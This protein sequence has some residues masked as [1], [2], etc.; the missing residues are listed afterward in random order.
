MKKIVVIDGQ[1]GK[2][3]R[4]VIERLISHSE[5]TSSTEIPFKITAVGTNSIAAATMLKAG[6]HDCA[7]GENSVIVNC[8][9]ANVVIGPIGIVVA[10]ALHGEVTAVMAAAV[11]ACKAQK[12]L[13][14][15]TRC[16][17]VIAGTTPLSASEL[18]DM[19]VQKVLGLLYG[20]SSIL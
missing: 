1:G 6:A 14:P 5:E 20:E 18:V 2:L 3:G 19:A 13:L 10:D 8:R 9:D 7:T 16:R 15:V 11:G 12:I 17:V 4:L